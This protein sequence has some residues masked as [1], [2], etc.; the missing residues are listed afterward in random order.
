MSF[1]FP[2]LLA[3]VETLLKPGYKE[4]VV[5]RMKQRLSNMCTLAVLTKDMDL[6]EEAYLEAEKFPSTVTEKE[7]AMEG[8]NLNGPLYDGSSLT[9]CFKGLDEFLVKILDSR[10]RKR[11]MEF[12]RALDDSQMH[13]NIVEFQLLNADE[14]LRT[15]MVMPRLMSTLEHYKRLEE[16]DQVKK[17]F[18]DMSSALQYL[19][20]LN[21]AHVDVKP[22]NICVRNRGFVLIDLGSI[23]RLGQKGAAATLAYV[24]RDA[25]ITHVT[26]TLDWWMLGMTLAEMGCGRNSIA[27]GEGSKPRLS[28]KELVEHLEKHLLSN[29]SFP[30]WKDQILSEFY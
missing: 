28:K 17:L 24:P 7:L 20:N 26:A 21:F 9:I 19:H 27:I 23:S 12:K 18:S 8:W 30:L 22:A 15:L 1:T 10:E 29:E 4:G 3:G 6:A 16:E 2:L 13:P 11:I 5:R 14:E 25:D